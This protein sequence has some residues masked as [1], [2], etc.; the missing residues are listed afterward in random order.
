MAQTEELLRCQPTQQQQQ[1][2]MA[3]V[4]RFVKDVELEKRRDEMRRNKQFTY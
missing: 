4:T 1:L 2:K 3:L